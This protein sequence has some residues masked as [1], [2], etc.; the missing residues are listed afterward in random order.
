MLGAITIGSYAVLA[1]VII[2]GAYCA[3]SALVSAIEDTTADDTTMQVSEN[4][5][6]SETQVS[7]PLYDLPK[8]A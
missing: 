3:V 4:L 6:N 2:L 8:A 7:D 1:T 5:S